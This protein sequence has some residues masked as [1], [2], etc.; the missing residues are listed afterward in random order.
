MQT[1]CVPNK[2]IIFFTLTIILSVVSFF[3]WAGA[4]AQTTLTISNPGPI[5]AK[6]TVTVTDPSLS[7]RVF[8][9]TKFTKAEA[10]PAGIV[11]IT[12]PTADD[13]KFVITPTKSGKTTLS[14]EYV[15]GTTTLKGT[16]NVIVPYKSVQ[17][18]ELP[19]NPLKLFTGQTPSFK[20]FGVD[21][22]GETVR[23][24]DAVVTSSDANVVKASFVNQQLALDAQ[25]A[26]SADITVNVFGVDSSPLKVQVKEGISKI[27]VNNQGAVGSGEIQMVIPESETR[28]VKVKILGSKGTEFKRSEVPLQT[29]VSGTG[30]G[31]AAQAT[32]DDK[33]ENLL[34]ITTPAIVGPGCTSA[35]RVVELRIPAGALAATEVLTRIKIAVTQKVG[36]VKLTSTSPVLTQNGKITITAEV[37]DRNNAA[38]V[39]APDVQF[40]LEDQDK[41]SIWVTLVKEGNTATLVPRNPTD[42]EIKEKNDDQLVP[43]PSQ[44]VVVAKT[45]LDPLSPEVISKIV[46]GLGQVI[47]FDLLK[48]K[49]NLMDER[50]ASDLYGKVTSEEYYVLTVRLFNNLKDQ[51]T[52]EFNGNS[53]LAY[54]SSIELAVQLEKKFDRDGT[55]SYFPNIISKSQAKGLVDSD[56]RM[57]A[58]LAAQKTLNAAIDEQYSTRQDAIKKLNE[59]VGKRS[60]AER[61]KVIAR[62]TVDQTA[63]DQAFNEANAAVDEQHQAW[64]DAEAA[65][66]KASAAEEQVR[67]LRAEMA[68]KALDRAA[69]SEALLTDPDTAIDD[70]KWHPMSPGDLIRFNPQ[71]SSVPSM[72]AE[73]GP[74]AKLTD[75]E[76]HA[77]PRRAPVPTPI[78]LGPRN[79]E[80][81][82]EE[83]PPCRGVITY[84]PFTFEM[85]VNTV[86]RRDERSVRS[87]VFKALDLIG[88]G[89]SFVSSVA[90]PGPSSDLPIGLEKYRNLLIPGL[91]KL[92]PNYKEQQR[93]NIVSQ[94]M[95]EIEEIPFASDITR[96]IFIPKKTIHGLLR[97]HDVRISEVC[98]FFFRIQVAIVTK[99]ATIEQGLIR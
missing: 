45:R 2:R 57:Q 44:I 98:P 99:S 97:G 9:H 28:E 83:D 1:R 61:L 11:T 49:L 74:L 55:D 25:N 36:F 20:L 73:S 54:S 8:D 56:S 21:V 63:R 90:V 5:T 15:D 38:K 50:T 22:A 91:D 43:R 39:P 10:T 18:E 37:F 30:C 60:R 68:R 24:T 95:K 34:K 72:R 92:Y 26:G 23:L 4:H 59:E 69:D 86:D 31:V 7:S 48:V 93:Q 53:I 67:K 47:G 94:A 14:I 78:E 77:R 33:D 51:R 70:G 76:R 27:E 29:T 17:A 32:Y 52:G 82:E 84:R 6:T 62:A 46:I 87:R 19:G 42:R 64:I 85:M 65:L 81:E 96:V 13:G 80:E 16:L 3:A 79:E 12:K 35:D 58:I 40:S 88:T 71:V 89:T 66:D 75:T 41:N